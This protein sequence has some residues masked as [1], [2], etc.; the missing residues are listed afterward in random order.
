MLPSDDR[1]LLKKG[2]T[3][4]TTTNDKCGREAKYG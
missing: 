2:E 3:V 4:V 1:S